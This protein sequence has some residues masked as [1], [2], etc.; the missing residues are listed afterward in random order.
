MFRLC[1]NMTFISSFFK[2]TTRMY[3]GDIKRQVEIFYKTN[4]ITIS[5]VAKRFSIPY[6]TIQTWIKNE[7]WKCGEAIQN[8]DTTKKEVVIRNFDVVT[9]TAKDNIKQ[10]IEQNLGENAYNI[11]KVI[12]DSLLNESSETLLLQA[13]SLNHINKTLAI[14]AM[15]AKKAILDLQ[16][17]DVNTESH[18]LALIAS[19]EKVNKIFIDLK[20]SLY[21]DMKQ[22]NQT[23]DY[24]DM[25][26]AEILEIINKPDM[27]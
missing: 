3:S 11:D 5:Q 16:A 18:K 12:L 8:I 6:T 25:S 10:E 23:L 14:N 4:K 21:G 20:E 19:S 17:R 15:I 13:M 2:E 7:N 22:T 24:S 1:L 27:E 9:K 26:D